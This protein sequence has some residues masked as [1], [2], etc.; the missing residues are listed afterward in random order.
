MPPV[1][2]S[3]SSA[4]TPRTAQFGSARDVALSRIRFRRAITLLMM[5]LL[6]PGS[7]QL[8]AGR[9]SVG[10]L[11]LRVWLAVCGLLAVVVLVGFMWHGL[12]YWLPPPTAGVGAGP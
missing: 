7:A 2:S 5:T 4:A 12:V 3:G 8:V 6:V 1:S 10:R 9:R 11:A